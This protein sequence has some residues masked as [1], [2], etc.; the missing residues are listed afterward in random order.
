MG[1][2]AGMDF[3]LFVTNNPS[4]FLDPFGLIKTSFK[5]LKIMKIRISKGYI[6]PRVDLSGDCRCEKGKWRLEFNFKVQP[7][8]FISSGANKLRYIE[9]LS[10]ELNH[11]YD[12]HDWYSNWKEKL[13]EHEENM[14]FNS[15]SECE[16]FL[17]NINENANDSAYKNHFD[18]VYNHD[19]AFVWIWKL[20]AHYTT[21]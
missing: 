13:I 16:R 3:Y 12:W 14:S 20:I 6:E 1:V 10:H 9:L 11:F 7:V 18:S 17:R 5:L 19:G 4:N 2:Y 21:R 8:I 15:C